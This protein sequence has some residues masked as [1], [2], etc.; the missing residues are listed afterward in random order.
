MNI[1]DSFTHLGRHLIND[2]DIGDLREQYGQE[3]D[4]RFLGI[5]YYECESRVQ[6]DYALKFV[7]ASLRKE[8]IPVAMLINY[9]DIPPHIDDNLTV[10]MNFYCIGKNF[11]TQMYIPGD[12]P[13]MTK[14]GQ[15]DGD[16]VM[17]DIESVIPTDSF[18]AKPGDVYALDVK[19]IHGVHA[20]VGNNLRVGLQL[21][22]YS[23]TYEELMNAL[24]DEI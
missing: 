19:Q 24:R 16:G 17:F 10:A 11:T 15:G 23:V 20:E 14:T 8:F 7:P 13:V 6:T 2:L 5:S 21:H 4:G 12:N 18:I 9:H 3:V 1:G 22:S